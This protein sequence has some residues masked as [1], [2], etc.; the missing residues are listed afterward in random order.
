MICT[1]GSLPVS[2]S[3]HIIKGESD[4]VII[5]VL[6]DRK[7]SLA[8]TP[9]GYTFRRK[10]LPNRKTFFITSLCILCLAFLM[11]SCERKRIVELKKEHLFSIP[12][13]SAEEEI[14][15][16]REKSG[17]FVGPGSVS[18]RNGFFFVV[19]A[20]NQ[21]IM[22]ITTPGDVILTIADGTLEESVNTDVLR[23]K[24]KRY[25]DF[26]QIGHIAVDGEN[27]LYVE[28]LFLQKTETEAVIDIFSIDSGIGQEE[29]AYE[30]SYRSY[31][32][33]FDRVGSFLYRLGVNGIDSDPFYF[34]YRTEIDSEGNLIVVTGD[35]S[36]E[37]WTYYLFDPQGNRLE[38]FTVNHQDLMEETT[39]ADQIDFIMD[40]VPTR[41]PDEIVCWFSH[42]K[43]SQDTKEIRKEEDLWGE[44]IEIED[45]DRYREKQ[46][47]ER[48]QSD[49]GIRDLLHYDLLFYD[50]KSN[51]IDHE[52][53]W[54]TGEGNKVETT[55]EFIGIDQNMNCFFWKYI[56]RNKSVITILE[57][58]GS[59]VTKRSFLFEDDGIWMD[60]EVAP[61]GSVTAVKVDEWKVHFYRWRSDKLIGSKHER[62]TFREFILN[63][64]EGFRNANR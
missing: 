41:T 11:E 30:E 61:D 52:Q 1:K 24:Q 6:K 25:F 42:Y 29:G 9:G 64:V 8:K 18:F 51:S 44:E 63:K 53:R 62:V 15:I 33:K 55:E 48:E 23:T 50:L 28:D 46:R 19:D 56:D 27:N 54:E 12:I 2:L 5:L 60:L 20:V 4:G 58:D 36:W 3:N 10:P 32:L 31:I 17:R 43:T 7:T 34:V 16:L 57:P 39:E 40:I 35:D 49:Q 21:K 45:Y 38:G 14:G 22:K 37:T 59:F 47:D 13:G 26:N